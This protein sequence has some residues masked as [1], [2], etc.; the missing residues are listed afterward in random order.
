M[1]VPHASPHPHRFKP[2]TPV[3]HNTHGDGK[4]I[5]EWGPIVVFHGKCNRAVCSCED[6]YDVEFGVE[7][8]RF[9]HCCRSEY[10]QRIQW[11]LTGFE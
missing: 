5:G 7:P 6:V 10:L 3:H 9:L 11:S 2:G 4:V 8:H 1:P